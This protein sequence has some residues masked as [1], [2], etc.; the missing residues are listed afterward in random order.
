MNQALLLLPIVGLAYG[1]VNVVANLEGAAPPIS[2]DHFVP[3]E[4]N[5]ADEPYA[6][7]VELGRAVQFVDSAAMDWQTERRCVTCHTNGLYLIARPAIGSDAPAYRDARRFAESYLARYVIDGEPSRGQHG[8][9][10]GLVATAAFKAISDIQTDGQLNAVTAQ[11]LD[12]VWSLQDD[13]GA[14]VDWLKC[15]WGPYEADDHFGV[16]LMALAMGFAEGDPYTRTPTARAGVDKLRE[17]LDAHPPENLHQTGMLLWAAV[18]LHGLVDGAT[19]A[20]W[21]DALLDA[22]HEDG[23]WVL[24]ELGGGQWRRED[25]DPQDTHTDAYATAFAAH[26][27]IESGM[28][29]DDGPIAR[30]VAWLEQHQRAS[31]RWFTRSPRRDRSHYISHAATNFALMVLA[32]DK[33]EDRGTTAP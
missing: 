4:D 29:R 16:T 14:W 27:L 8:S 5:N 17:Y 1:A 22:Q 2:A 11:A 20:R 33:D 26:V 7:S 28:S 31:G 18:H 19:R 3:P 10:E 23:G 6:Q 32:G 25:G 12:H 15:N 9:T 24:A 13:S 30:A 21:A